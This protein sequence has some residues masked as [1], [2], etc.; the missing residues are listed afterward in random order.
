[1][2]GRG[3]WMEIKGDGWEAKAFLLSSF[4][5]VILSNWLRFMVICKVSFVFFFD[6]NVGFNVGFCGYA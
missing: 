6:S 1:M 5:S 2:N 4:G 3:I